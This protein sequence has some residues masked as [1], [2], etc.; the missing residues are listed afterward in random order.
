MPSPLPTPCARR[1]ANEESRHTGAT[2]TLFCPP[3]WFAAASDDGLALVDAVSGAR[4]SLHGEV[5]AAL[6]AGRRPTALGAMA[7]L[8]PTL[9]A[10]AQAL[11][12][13]VFEPLDRARLLRGGGYRQ[14]FVE[15]TSR[16]NERCSHCYAEAGPDRDVELD[17]PT[18]EATLRDAALLGFPM[19]QLTGGDP[20]LSRSLV[21][22]AELCAEL[23]IEVTEIYTNGLA[24][25]PSLLRRLHPMPISFAFSFYSHLPAH[26]D[27]ITAT[28]GSHRRTLQ[29]IGAALDSG[30][31]VRVSVILMDRNRDDLD[32]TLELLH[33][34]G[35]EPSAIG[36]DVQ[37]SVGR[38]LM[39]IRP[40]DAPHH[41]RLGGHRTAQ[42]AGAQA[43]HATARN[44]R[45]CVAHDGVVYPCILA[46]DRPLGNVHERS[47]RQIL[48]QASA[49]SIDLDTLVGGFAD[50][51]ERLTCWECRVRSAVLST[52][53]G[54]RT[55]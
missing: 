36:V 20:L 29:A 49:L 30:K 28:A 2:E 32:G 52:A 47:L 7:A 13:A 26:H 40:K 4:V 34:L 6:R 38:G 39:T 45:A 37:R 42:R 44:G 18:L 10:L 55:S 27:A 21:L 22:A 9:G 17:W 46:R 8:E 48:E 5:A 1:S 16:C 33:S 11:E 31:P 50:S 43:G 53:E 19:V 3:A 12:H 24:L 41:D 54:V 15:L 25:T 35:I 23:G 51:E 14:L